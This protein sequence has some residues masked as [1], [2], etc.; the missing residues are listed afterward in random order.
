MSKGQVYSG[1]SDCLV[2][3]I[4]VAKHENKTL[5]NKNNYDQC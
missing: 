5:R 3:N 4:V 2:K 1:L